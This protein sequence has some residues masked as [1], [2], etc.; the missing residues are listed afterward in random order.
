MARKLTKKVNSTRKYKKKSIH[1][2]GGGE[3]D[4]VAKL[5]TKLNGLKGLKSRYEKH[6]LIRQNNIDNLRKSLL[7]L[8]KNDNSLSDKIDSL[9]DSLQKNN[10]YEVLTPLYEFINKLELS[11]TVKQITFS[12]KH[13]SDNEDSIVNLER[14]FFDKYYEVNGELGFM[15]KQI[16][17]LQKQMNDMGYIDNK[18]QIHNNKKN[19][20]KDNNNKDDI[21]YH[22]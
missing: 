16:N 15:T 3:V 2:K 5:Q 19:K 17:N 10:I 4:I 12:L 8:K 14:V 11:S 6:K 21:I 20:I 9:L 13:L 1:K 22:V 18:K 7:N